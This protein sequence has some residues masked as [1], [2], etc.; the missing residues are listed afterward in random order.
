MN[1]L[2]LSAAFPAL[3][4]GLGLGALAALLWLGSLAP[5]YLADTFAFCLPPAW[6]ES[7]RAV[8]VKL[9]GPAAACGWL[10]WGQRES[11]QRA[12]GKRFLRALGFPDE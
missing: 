10:L 12:A 11:A 1:R 5:A 6:I 9:L 4:W 8:P 3:T 7:A 2:L